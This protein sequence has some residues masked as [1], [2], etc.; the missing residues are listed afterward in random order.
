MGVCLCVLCVCMWFTDNLP[1]E[2]VA[3]TSRGGGGGPR[4]PGPDNCARL[5]ILRWPGVSDAV[6]EF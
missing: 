1:I 6:A 2:L 4:A 3:P 5:A